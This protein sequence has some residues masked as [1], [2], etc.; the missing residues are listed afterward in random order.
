MSSVGTSPPL[1]ITKLWATY[2]KGTKTDSELDHLS[3]WGIV[4]LDVDHLDQYPEAF[5]S[6]VTTIQYGTP[7]YGYLPWDTTTRTVLRGGRYWHV[8]ECSFSSHISISD[9][10]FDYPVSCV[11]RYLV[12]HKDD[13]RFPDSITCHEEMPNI[14]AFSDDCNII[15]DVPWPGIVNQNISTLRLN[16]CQHYDLAKL[17]QMPNLK[18]LTII[19]KCPLAITTILATQP[20]LQSLH[21]MLGD[22]GDNDA[23]SNII[24][25]PDDLK[26]LVTMIVNHNHIHEIRTFTN[27]GG[28]AFHE[29]QP[30][31]DLALKYR[32]FIYNQIEIDDDCL[33]IIAEYLFGF[34]IHIYKKT[35]GSSES[36][37]RKR[38][39]TENN[40]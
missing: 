35:T 27:P 39:F 28:S 21:F 24:T 7:S 17:Q 34:D 1:S 11:L 8:K 30:I 40:E 33:C 36:T 9:T 26:N 15:L 23:E 5:W 16:E 32:A 19:R 31:I 25:E 10:A 2:D 12:K 18:H 37:T 4:E 14:I 20:K 38:R 13:K 3:G 22:D 6:I 29:N